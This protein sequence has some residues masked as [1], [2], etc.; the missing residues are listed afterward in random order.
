MLVALKPLDRFILIS[1][2]LFAFV[3]TLEACSC[4]SNAQLREMRKVPSSDIEGMVDQILPR[5]RLS[6]SLAFVARKVHHFH[7]VTTCYVHKAKKACHFSGQ[8]P[9][10]SIRIN[11]A[12][13]TATHP[14]FKQIEIVKYPFWFHAALRFS[15]FFVHLQ[16]YASFCI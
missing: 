16:L 12:T 6:G 11:A 5:R 8:N 9:R 14:P 15:F 2:L 13:L 10:V 4:W 3:T 1:Y 7:F